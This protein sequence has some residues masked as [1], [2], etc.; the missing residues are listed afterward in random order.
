MADT[1]RE[2]MMA[3]VKRRQLGYL[4]RVLRGCGPE[5]DCLLG[6]IAGKRARG[7]QR[8]K[9]MDGIKEMVRKE[10]VEEVVKLSRDRRV[11][12]HSIVATVT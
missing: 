2:L 11:W 9:Y 3:T 7:R 5:R 1:T 4:G 8:V 6:M 12:W 10:K